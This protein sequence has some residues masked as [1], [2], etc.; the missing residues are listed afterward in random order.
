VTVA[1][2]PEALVQP[3][4][5]ALL[6]RTLAMAKRGEIRAVIVACHQRYDYTGN[7]YAMGDGHAAQ[8]VYAAECVKARIIEECS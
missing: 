3:D 7:C 1:A 2:L 8:L 6:E 4:V 5:V